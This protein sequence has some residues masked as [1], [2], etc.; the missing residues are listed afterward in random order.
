MQPVDP[1]FLMEH[2]RFYDATR[3]RAISVE[4]R[5]FEMTTERG[6]TGRVKIRASYLPPNFQAIPEGPFYRPKRFGEQK[7]LINTLHP[8]YTKVYDVS[9]EIKAAL[10]VLLFVLAEAELEAEGGFESSH[11][12]A[13]TG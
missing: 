12:V 10:E 4:T 11:H 8:F 2:G 13:R 1:L 9:P 5:V 3:V 6:I 7:R